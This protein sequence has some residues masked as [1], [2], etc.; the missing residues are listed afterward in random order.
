[1]T[2]K[3]KVISISSIILIFA[4]LFFGFYIYD[5]RNNRAMTNLNAQIVSMNQTIIQD[6]QTVNALHDQLSTQV[7]SIHPLQV[8]ASSSKA[9]AISEVASLE[10]EKPTEKPDLE[11]AVRPFELALSDC[12]K[13]NEQTQ[14]ALDT[15]QQENKAQDVVIQD[16]T[17]QINTI[18]TDLA[19]TTKELKSETIRK[20]LWRDSAIGSGAYILL[21]ILLHF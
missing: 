14:A 3:T 4:A 16:Q 21:H 13:V 19:D 9:Q 10:T 12:E 6:K 8:K 15:S 20:K 5:S 1:M 11:A 2:I 7:A 18:S 17:T